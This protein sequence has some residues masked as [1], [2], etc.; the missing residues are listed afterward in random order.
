M[1]SCLRQAAASGYVNTVR[2]LLKAG[3]DVNGFDDVEGKKN[4]IPSYDNI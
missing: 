4:G 2:Q 3:A 1:G